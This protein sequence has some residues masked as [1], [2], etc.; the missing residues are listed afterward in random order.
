[1]SWQPRIDRYAVSLP[2]LGSPCSSRAAAKSLLEIQF[3]LLLSNS[4]FL[5]LL[6]TINRLLLHTS[7]G[8]NLLCRFAANSHQSVRVLVQVTGSP[9]EAARCSHAHTANGISHTL[10]CPCLQNTGCL[11]NF[12]DISTSGRSKPDA[13]AHIRALAAV[14]G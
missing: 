9:A 10:F 5:L 12:R 2:R 4:P 8:Q 1:M 7:L 3:G 14:G 6:A 13:A 11:D